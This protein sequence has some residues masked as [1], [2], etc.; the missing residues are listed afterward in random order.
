MRQDLPKFTIDRSDWILGNNSY[1]EL[2]D[3]GFTLGTV[4]AN[5]FSKP[6]LLTATPQMGSNVTTGIKAG[7][8]AGWGQGNDVVGLT[9]VL[10]AVTCDGGGSN[11]ADFN[12][13]NLSTG[14]FTKVGATYTG[15]IEQGI[16]DTK[17][18][19]N[20]FY[21]TT[22][23][24]V[25]KNS[26]DLSTRDTTFWTGTSGHPVLSGFSAH[27]ME[28]YGDILYI[29]DGQYLHQLDGAVTS[30]QVFDLGA[31]WVITALANYNGLLYIAAE[32]YINNAGT[33]HGISKLFTWDG[34]SDSFL[35]DWPL[36]YRVD[37][38]YVYENVLYIFDKFFMGYWDG[39]RRKSL[40]AT[41][42]QIF[43]HQITTTSDSMFYANGNKITRY[44]TPIFGGQ[45]HF[46]DYWASVFQQYRAIRSFD[47]NNMLTSENGTVN[48][49]LY[50]ISNVNTPSAFGGVAPLFNKRFFKRNVRI[51]G[52]VVETDQIPS[53]GTILVGYYDDNNVLR[54]FGTSGAS[55]EGKYMYKTEEG[56][57]VDAPPTRYVQPILQT[58]GQVYIRSVTYYFEV[59]ESNIDDN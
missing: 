40:R 16:S 9:M 39:A 31:D 30:T 3:G 17:Y 27:P 29:A 57:A 21:T 6:G 56:D 33:R 50:Y 2:P 15:S 25:I 12:L 14:A 22:A 1:D 42:N 5:V 35:D 13:V 46:Y 47:S 58:F 38:L 45:R 48:S 10:M 52:V 53:Q 54:N 36:D 37:S 55:S 34:F 20:A 44:G 32:S 7:G 41:G 24:N 59:S 51:R 11:D 18:Y 26:I 8:V 23:T 4:G 49:S 43:P 28:V 19:K